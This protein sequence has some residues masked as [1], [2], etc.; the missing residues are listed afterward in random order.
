MCPVGALWEFFGVHVLS[1][2]MVVCAAADDVGCMCVY[3]CIYVAYMCVCMH[4]GMLVFLYV[5]RNVDM[6]MLWLYV[7]VHVC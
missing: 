2:W 4:V 1:A 5:C 3:A 7:R 6:L